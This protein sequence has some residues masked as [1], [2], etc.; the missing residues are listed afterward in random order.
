VR[1]AGEGLIADGEAP[2][3]LSRLGDMVARAVSSVGLERSARLAAAAVVPLLLP[4]GGLATYAPLLAGLSAYVLL[5]ALASRDQYLRAAD[6]VVGAALLV[7]TGPA[8]VAFLPFVLVTIAG[9]ASKGGVR[10]GLAAGGTLA[11]VLLVRLLVTGEFGDIGAANVIPI[12]LLLPLAGLTAAAA[13]DVLQDRGVRD[14]MVLQQANRL[15]S[16]LRD[17]A[18][19]IPGGLDVTT[20]SAALLAESR[21]VPGVEAALVLVEDHGML[22]SAAATGMGDRPVPPIR[23]E[24]LER[25]LTGGTSRFHAPSALPPALRP[26]CT[27]HPDWIVLALGESHRPAGVLLVGFDLREPARRARPRLNSLAIDGRLALENARLFDGTRVR[28]ADAARRNVAGDLHD[29]VAQSL[30]HLRIE[31]EL[32]ARDADQDPELARLARV[33]DTA[34]LDLR[35]TIAGLRAPLD[36][37]LGALLERHIDDL[38]SP[39]GPSIEFRRE[40]AN[41]LDPERAEE[42][43]RVAQEA[44]SNALRHASAETIE[45]VLVQ[46]DDEVRLVV[47]DDGTGPDRPSPHGGGGVGLRSMRERAERLHGELDLERRP[48]G[49]SRLVLTLPTARPTERPAGGEHHGRRRTDRPHRARVPATPGHATPGHATPSPPA[50]EDRS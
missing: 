1:R 20:V 5:T 39:R 12:S 14:R 43:L 44:L 21:G 18:D 31:L 35:A 45:V 16:S 49:G 36:H 13:S 2:A 10:A 6:L 22:R 47:R 9:P 25:Q 30:A 48:D 32:R 11:L 17:L 41:R 42:V 40:G 24:D 4:D 27:G 33:A 23:V 46:D 28:A 3:W 29:G 37:D 7:T 19:E 8:I 15:L 38:Q 26:A 34:L 50:S